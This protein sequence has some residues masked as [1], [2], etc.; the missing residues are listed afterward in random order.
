MSAKPNE[1]K[2]MKAV[3]SDFLVGLIEVSMSDQDES[4]YIV[5]E[6]CDIDLDRHLKYHTVDGSLSPHNL[7]FI[8][9]TSSVKP[10]FDFTYLISLATFLMTTLL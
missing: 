7:R 5:M 3:K 8:F 6:L 1:L 10:V 9:M 2:V 4:M